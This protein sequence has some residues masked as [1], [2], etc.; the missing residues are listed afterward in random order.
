MNTEG[1]SPAE[2]LDAQTTSHIQKRFFYHSFPRRG[3]STGVE[4]DK[5]CQILAAI[6]DFGLLL[7]P[8]TIQWQQPSSGCASPRILPM[9]LQKRACFTELSPC[10]LPQH[11]AKFGQFALEFEIDTLRQLGAFPVLYVPQPINAADASSVGIALL[12][13]IQD[14][15]AVVS[16]LAVLD[17]ILP[18]AVENISYDVGH[19][20]SP[21][22]RRVF[23]IN[24]DEAKNILSAIGYGVTPWGHLEGG[25]SALNN[26][27]Y[28]TDNIKHDRALEYYRQREWRITG[29]FY[30]NGTQMLRELT[31]LEKAQLLEID[32]DFFEGKIQTDSGLVDRLSQLLVYPGLND[33]RMIEK[34]RRVIVPAKAV[35]CVAG[36]LAELDNPPQVFVL[37]EA[38]YIMNEQH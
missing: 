6:R 35:D 38:P 30:V 19:A 21:D 29:N 27:F 8:E 1:S 15:Y 26:F 18:S 28:P 25:L 32:K 20:G 3:A 14:A 9:L 24:R 11:A 10:E 7:T 22:S 17:G 31:P 4:T 36:I 12:A 2:R 37:G 5:G 16:R 33:M 23:T 34:A 13:I